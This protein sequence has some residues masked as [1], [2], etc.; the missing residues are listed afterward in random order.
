MTFKFEVTPHENEDFDVTNHNGE[1]IVVDN[2]GNNL[3]YAETK[4]I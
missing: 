2:I 1:Q 4:N 3:Q